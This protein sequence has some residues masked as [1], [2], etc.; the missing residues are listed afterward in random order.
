M[1]TTLPSFCKGL[2]LVRFGAILMLLQLALSIVMTVKAFSASSMDDSRNALDWL[3]YVMLANAG[4]TLLMCVGAARSIPELARV[5]VD[6]RGLVIAAAGFAIATA[7]MLWSYH[8]VTSF[9][10]VALD[11]TSSASDVL[12]ASER[13]GSL[14]SVAIVKDLAY[15]IGLVMMIRTLQRSA[16]ANDQ[17]A[18]RDEAG[19]M[20]RALIVMVVADLFFQLTYGLGGGIGILGAVGSLLVAGYWIFCHLRLVRFLANAAYFV[21]EPHDLPVATARRTPVDR[22]TR[23]APAPRPRTAPSPVAAVPPPVPPPV[24][25]APPPVPRPVIAAPPPLAPVAPE[26]SA[27]AGE[28]DDSSSEPR[29]LR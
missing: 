5:R 10:A 13:L 16:A 19:S 24:I 2:K 23:R 26:R 22:E 14:Q 15:G 9:I 3:E 17:L 12:A 7:A 29:F 25:A 6:I 20:S 28:A 11:P 18:L 27:S 4:A 21:N 1:A 8:A